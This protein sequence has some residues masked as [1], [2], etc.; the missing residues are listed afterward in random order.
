MKIVHL[1]LGKKMPDWA[2]RYNAS[3]NLPTSQEDGRERETTCWWQTH[4]YLC[5]F[6]VKKY[7]TNFYL[8]P[9][10]LTDHYLF[11]FS[12]EIVAFLLLP[13]E[14]R[15]L[16]GQSK[17]FCLIE[18]IQKSGRRS[19]SSELLSASRNSQLSLTCGLCV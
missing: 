19:L 4:S 3:I 16:K 9:S 8:Q 2:E 1:Q 15:L 12:E 17:H 11:L 18:S 10:P 13:L 7:N 6:C 5:H 14:K